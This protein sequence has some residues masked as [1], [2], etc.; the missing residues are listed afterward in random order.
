MYMFGYSDKR[1]A[2]EHAPVSNAYELCL[3]AVSGMIVHAELRD[4]TLGTRSH[5]IDKF[6]A[7]LLLQTLIRTKNGALGHR[8]KPEVR[9]SH[10]SL[11]HHASYRYLALRFDVRQL[12]CRLNVYRLR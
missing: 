5:L 11:S 7:H 10:A 3:L 9:H 2:S 12:Y 8:E 1:M 6:L 4:I